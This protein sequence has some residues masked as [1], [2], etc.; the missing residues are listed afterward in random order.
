MR[1]ARLYETY[2]HAGSLLLLRRSKIRWYLAILALLRRIGI[3][4]GHTPEIVEEDLGR[5]E[6]GFVDQVRLFCTRVLGFPLPMLVDELGEGQL[7]VD[8]LR[9]IAEH[10]AA[11]VRQGHPSRY[12]WYPSDWRRTLRFVAGYDDEP[13]SK[14]T[15]EREPGDDEDPHAVPE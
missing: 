3:D 2:V 1:R 7:E 11:R 10:L 6:G 15:P 12:E 4:K 9:R 8:D 5:I 14:P 13:V